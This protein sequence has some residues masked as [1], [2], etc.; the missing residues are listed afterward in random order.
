V[1]FRLLAGVVAVLHGAFLVYVVFGGFMAW[2]WPKTIWLH[3]AAVAWGIG[4]VAIGWE[5]PLTDLEEWFA[6][7]GGDELSDGGFVDRYVEDRL[8]PE[9]FTPWVRTAAVCS[10]VVSWYGVIV[11]RQRRAASRSA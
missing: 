7:R 3:V 1:V 11:R 2:R 6:E 8:Y 4:I 10:V 9:R 5:C